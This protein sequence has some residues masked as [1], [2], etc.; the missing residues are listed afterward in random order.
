MW[1]TPLS[2]CPL[3]V[4]NQTVRVP[5]KTHP[6]AH[7]RQRVSHSLTR[8]HHSCCKNGLNNE[9]MDTCCDRAADFHSWSLGR[10]FMY[11]HWMVFKMGIPTGANVRFSMHCQCLFP[12]ASLSLPLISHL[13]RPVN[14]RGFGGCYSEA[15]QGSTHRMYLYWQICSYLLQDWTIKSSA[16]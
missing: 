6:S 15:P 10:L 5:V 12:T 4:A 2:F 3:N 7:C 9:Q 8:F 1:S 13:T 14:G 11:C 16:N